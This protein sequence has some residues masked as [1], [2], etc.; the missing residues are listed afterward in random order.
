MHWLQK[1]P[2]PEA[3]MSWLTGAF[4]HTYALTSETVITWSSYVPF[5]WYIFYTCAL[6]WVTAKTWSNYVPAN[7]CLSLS[8]DSNA[9]NN[10]EMQYTPICRGIFTSFVFA[11][12][13]F[14]RNIIYIN[15]YGS[16]GYAFMFPHRLNYYVCQNCGNEI[17]TYNSNVYSTAKALR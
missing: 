3:I 11:A 14:Y 8:L 10:Y 12:H 7:W 13:F 5:N 4:I 16:F 9:S 17:F 2:L 15:F 6:T 1:R